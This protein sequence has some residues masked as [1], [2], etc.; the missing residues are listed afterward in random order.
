MVIMQDIAESAKVRRGTLSY[1][2]TGKYKQAKFYY[3]K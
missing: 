3:R 1:A 2:L